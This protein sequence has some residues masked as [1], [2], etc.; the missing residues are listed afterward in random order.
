[1]FDCLCRVLKTKYHF[2]GRIFFFPTVLL[3]QMTSLSDPSFFLVPEEAIRNF[4]P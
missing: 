4:I 3:I 2:L 1:M